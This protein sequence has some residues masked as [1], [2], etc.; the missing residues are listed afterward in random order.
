MKLF[1]AVE[2]NKQGTGRV[3]WSD[4]VNLV[5]FCAESLSH[6]PD[7]TELFNSLKIPNRYYALSIDIK[8]NWVIREIGETTLFTVP[9]IIEHAVAD[10]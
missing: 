3:Q 5:V 8:D 4:D 2:H 6:W 7:I 10:S 9:T 1:I